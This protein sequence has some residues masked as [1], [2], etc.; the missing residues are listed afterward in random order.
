MSV[1]THPLSPE[2]DN[3]DEAES[4]M[5]GLPRGQHAF[6]SPSPNPNRWGSHPRFSIL[7]LA[8]PIFSQIP[9]APHLLASGALLGPGVYPRPESVKP[10]PTRPGTPL[11]PI[12]SL[13]GSSSSST[14]STPIITLFLPS[15][16]RKSLCFLCSHRPRSLGAQCFLGGVLFCIHCVCARASV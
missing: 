14:P 4:V 1:S 3:P 16:R 10:A 2:S 7:G 8:H 11:F 15:S 13:H 12:P 5:G 6:K 9:T